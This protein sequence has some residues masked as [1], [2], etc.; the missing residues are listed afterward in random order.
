[1]TPRYL[2][3]KILVNVISHRRSLSDALSVL[4]KDKNIAD[5]PFI[6]ALCYGVCRWYFQLEVTARQLLTKPL[7]KK[8]E[9]IYLLILM[10]LYQLM[11]MHLPDYAAVSETVAVADKLKKPWAKRLINAVLRN[12]QRSDLHVTNE[13]DLQGY[14]SHPHWIIQKL[15]QDW[16]NHWT[17]ILTAN[18]QH[19]PLSLRINQKKIT[20][21]QYIK[22]LTDAGLTALIIPET[23]SGIYLQ[24]PLDVQALPGFIAGDVSV[25]DGAAQLAAALLQLKPGQRVLDA[26]AAPG[27][28]TS[29]ILEIASEGIDLIALDKDIDR[30]N[31]LED[32]LA[33]LDQ[34]AQRVCCDAGEVENWW[35]RKLFDRILLD[36]PCSAVG[37]VRRHPDI[38]LL[39]KASDIAQLTQQ[40]LRL[41]NALWPL[42]KPNGILL[43]ATCSIFKDENVEVIKAFLAAHLDGR[44]EK[45]EQNWGLA[46]A[47]GRQILPGMHGMDGFYYAC[48]R[49]Y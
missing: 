39:R 25:Q 22:K 16:P 42:L 9:D 12:F 30:L 19:P 40:Q 24:D 15:Q 45:I 6:Q 44:E 43:Y 18:N 23:A 10:G 17:S 14:Y 31:L 11:E 47:F 7:K 13:D 1:M 49:K 21:D 29:H 46:C 33:R 32:N 41:L 4:N 34:K 5:H 8:D 26:C 28:K 38:K 3:V 2:T 20:R 27:G 37:V 35:D 36:A 48:L